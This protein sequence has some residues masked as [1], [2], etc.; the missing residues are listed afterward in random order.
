MRRLYANFN[1]FEFD[2][3][4]GGHALD[5][6]AVQNAKRAIDIP[7]RNCKPFKVSPVINVSVNVHQH[8]SF[9]RN[10]DAAIFLYGSDNIFPDAD[11][12][13]GL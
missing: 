9:C 3:D 5:K 11:N 6:F 12:I 1:N 7:R 4:G 8:F 2:I 13:H 10:A